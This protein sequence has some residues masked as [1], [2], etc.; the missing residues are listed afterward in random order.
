MPP[1]GFPKLRHGEYAVVCAE[2]STGIVLSKGGK[3]A[4]GDSDRYYLFP[5]ENL[6]ANF[7]QELVSTNPSWESAVLDCAGN[8]I[9]TYQNTNVLRITEQKEHTPWWRRWWFN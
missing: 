8:V 2:A 1:K 5:T 7:A 4:L 9:K 6:A 3:R